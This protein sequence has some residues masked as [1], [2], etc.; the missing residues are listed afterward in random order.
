MKTRICNRQ[1]IDILCQD[2]ENEKVVGFPTETVYGLAILS[3]SEKAFNQLI[4]LKHR[5]ITK[6]LSVM[7]SN[8]NKIKEIAYVNAQQEKIIR[9]FMPG[10]L[11]IILKAKPNLPFFMTLGKETIGIRIPNHALSLSI[12]D[13]IQKPLLVTSANLSSEKELLQAMDVYRTFNHQLVSMI[14]EDSEG[15]LASTIVDLTTKNLKILRK[16]PILEEQLLQIWEVN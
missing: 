13:K 4:E 2:L 11:T 10:P 1:E 6:P 7:V 15:Q 5:P 3:D 12:L 14:N 9:H 8:I 16:G